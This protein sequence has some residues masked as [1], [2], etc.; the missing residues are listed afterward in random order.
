MPQVQHE[1]N[2]KINK[3]E[4]VHIRRKLININIFKDIFQLDFVPYNSA[5]GVY[6]CFI[7]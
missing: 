5:D 7:D 6:R 2:F 3:H 1:V 4:V